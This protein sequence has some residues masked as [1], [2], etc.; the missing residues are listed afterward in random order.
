M[1]RAGPCVRPM[2]VPAFIA[3]IGRTRA[4]QRAEEAYDETNELFVIVGGGPITANTRWITFTLPPETE[5]PR[6]RMTETEV[7]SLI[8]VGYEN[9]AVRLVGAP[10][11]HPREALSVSPRSR[12]RSRPGKSDAL[13][14]DGDDDLTG[15]LDFTSAESARIRCG[16]LGRR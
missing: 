5:V 16:G 7:L 15:I 8:E 13:L 9:N 2:C 6:K 14:T 3:D 1:H 12:R 10:G 11:W 4:A